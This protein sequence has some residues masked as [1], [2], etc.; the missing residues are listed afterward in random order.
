MPGR[1]AKEL[2]KGVRAGE[3]GVMSDLDGSLVELWGSDG[4]ESGER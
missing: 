3:H 1:W 4:G 2:E